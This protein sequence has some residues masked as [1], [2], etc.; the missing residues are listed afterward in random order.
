MRKLKRFSSIIMAVVLMCSAV[1]MSGCGKDKGKDSNVDANGEVEYKVS[2]KD[3]LGNPYTSGVIV[4]FL[5][6]GSQVAMQVCDE[7][8]VA[9]KKLKAGDYDVELSF[10]DGD[11]GYHYNKEGLKVTS[12]NNEL[13]V[14]VAYTT[15][16][17]TDRQVYFEQKDFTAYSVLEG[18]TYVELDTEYRNFYMFTP[19]VAG[20]YEISVQDGSN[21]EIGYYGAPHYIQSV[22]AAEVK[23]NKFTVSISASM[24]G[25]GDTGTTVIVIGVDALEG[26]KN[27]VLG[28]ERIG[29]PQHTIEDEPWTIY[30]KTVDLSK[31]TLP[32][33]A[34]IGEFD[35]RASTDAY[36]LVF[37]ANDGFYHLDSEDGPLVLVRLGVDPSYV[38]C[39]K[40][41]LDKTGV[42]KYF[43]DENGEFVKKESYGECL[44]EYIEC[45]DEEQG[46]YPLTEDLK[47]IIQQKG[48]YAG[49]FD[50]DGNS[51]IFKDE[52]GNKVA[53]VN[54]EISWLFM[55][56]YISAN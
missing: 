33:G 37:N 24:I 30:K 52:N 17:S 53:G 40:T 14:I 39:F 46:V 48:E 13:D 8:G 16:N 28:V 10:T 42:N 31:Y 12:K 54:P 9:T 21:V 22:S 35:I 49:W 55:C 43:Y 6:D 44:L 56:C 23:D 20:T 29:D 51:Y 4:K 41:I 18:C 11:E 27:C 45:V 34:T 47:Y 15:A 2:A 26:T 50:A 38:A 7:T 25:K 5:Q 19:T 36:K 32:A 3:A 1:V